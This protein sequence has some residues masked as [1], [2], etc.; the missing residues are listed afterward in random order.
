MSFA[1]NNFE[2]NFSTHVF[3][4]SF[5][6]YRDLKIDYW[7]SRHILYEKIKFFPC[8]EVRILVEKWIVYAGHIFPE[9]ITTNMQIW[10]DFL[11]FKSAVTFRQSILQFA[12]FLLEINVN[13]VFY[14][15]TT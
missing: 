3:G 1:N 2:G 13:I 10:N 7:T 14:V 11:V 8:E 15:Q 6:H 5:W 9:S 4:N 12:L